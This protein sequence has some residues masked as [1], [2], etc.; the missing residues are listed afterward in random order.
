VELQQD[1]KG[2]KIHPVKIHEEL[3]RA[4]ERYLVVLGDKT[5]TVRR[6]N[7]WNKM[8]YIARKPSAAVDT[9]KAG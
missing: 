2:I 7:F 1:R 6:Q 8:N 4:V 9:A 3:E 5:Q